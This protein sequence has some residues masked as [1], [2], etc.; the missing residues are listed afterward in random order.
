M[1]G[2]SKLEDL[3]V[4]SYEC[5]FDF[6]RKTYAET[7]GV[8]GVLREPKPVHHPFSLDRTL[9]YQVNLTSCDMWPGEEARTRTQ[10]RYRVLGEANSPNKA[11]RLEELFKVCPDIKAISRDTGTYITSMEERDMIL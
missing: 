8:N 9:S 2:H 6:C 4:S 3:D 5:S 10:R 1:S 7:T 11:A